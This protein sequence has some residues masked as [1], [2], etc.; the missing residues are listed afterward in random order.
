LREEIRALTERD[1]FYLDDEGQSN[2]TDQMRHL[3]L[4]VFA[5]GLVVCSKD[6]C[7]KEAVKK[8]KLFSDH[9]IP[10]LLD[11]LKRAD[12][13][14]NNAFQSACCVQSLIACSDVTKQLVVDNGGV[15]SLEQAHAFGSRQARVAC[16]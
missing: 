1:V 11:E 6:G 2:H 16:R 8:Q 3:A 14:A 15:S 10:S 4:N 5:N 9:L 13:S 12:S 7:L